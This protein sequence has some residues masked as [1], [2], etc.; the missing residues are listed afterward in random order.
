MLRSF[1]LYYS[2][3]DFGSLVNVYKVSDDE[4]VHFLVDFNIYFVSELPF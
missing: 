1:G 2:Y 4:F 3:F